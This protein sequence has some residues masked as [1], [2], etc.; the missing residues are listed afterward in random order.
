M[1]HVLQ[2]Y[3]ITNKK[4][5]EYDEL[6]AEWKRF[7]N[8]E[9]FYVADKNIKKLLKEKVDFIFVDK[10]IKT[11][12]ITWEFLYELRKKNTHAKHVRVKDSFDLKEDHA[13]FKTGADDIIYLK[14]KKLYLKWKTIS[15]LRRRWESSTNDNVVFHRGLIIDK[16]NGE[17]ILNDKTI[18]LSKKEFQVLKVLVDAQPN[19]LV[20]RSYI[21]KT[22]WKHND[23]DPTRVV[24]QIIQNLKKKIGAHYFEIVRNK[25]IRLQ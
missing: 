7:F 1:R 5:K 24:Q 4:R 22:V 9:V 16:V 13:L 11:N 19:E 15:M 14:D 8:L 12:K 6:I 17:C 21:Y 3:F 10:E 20:E 2:I 25:G 18:E 23:D